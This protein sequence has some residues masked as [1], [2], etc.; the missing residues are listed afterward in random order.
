M[1]PDLKTMLAAYGREAGLSAPKEA[2]PDQFVVS[3]EGFTVHLANFQERGMLMLHAGIGV[4]PER[5]AERLCVLLLQSNNLFHDTGGTTLGLDTEAGAI[6][7]QVAWPHT[8]LD[9]RRFS[10]LFDNFILLAGNWMEKLVGFASENGHFTF[11][12]N[13]PSREETESVR[14]NTVLPGRLA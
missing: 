9:A 7:L 4:L 12:P 5:D 14:R 10:A 8:D 6:T 1:L 2:G 3:L 13:S 11:D